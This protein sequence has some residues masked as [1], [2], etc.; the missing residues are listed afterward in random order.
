MITEKNY[1]WL[2]AKLS[3][4]VVERSDYT[5]AAEARRSVGSTVAPPRESMARRDG[6]W[7]SCEERPERELAEGKLAAALCKPSADSRLS[8]D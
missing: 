3:S 8:D 2:K 6:C 1:F 5:V 4:A 7:G